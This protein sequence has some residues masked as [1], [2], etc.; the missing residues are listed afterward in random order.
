LFAHPQGVSILY[1]YAVSAAKGT[2]MAEPLVNQAASATTDFLTE[3]LGDADLVWRY[4]PLLAGGLARMGLQDVEGFPDYVVDIGRVLGRSL[5]ETVVN[6]LGLVLL[7]VGLVF[8]GPAGVVVVGALDLALSGAGVVQAYLRE[9]EQELAAGASDFLAADQRLAAPPDYSDTA[10]A[11]AAAFVSAFALLG[12]AKQ[13]LTAKRRFPEKLSKGRDWS[14]KVPLD[15]R[16]RSQ[17]FYPR[18]KLET[19]LDKSG[20]TPSLTA[21]DMRGT[22][23]NRSERV[24]SESERLTAQKMTKRGNALSPEEAARLGPGAP[25]EL[26]LEAAPDVGGLEGTTAPFDPMDYNTIPVEDIDVA[27]TRGGA[28]RPPG[29]RLVG[30]KDFE[31][32]PVANP[33]L[34]DP[35]QFKRAKRGSGP[36]VTREEQVHGVFFRESNP[37]ELTEWARRELPD[38]SFDPLIPSV[39]V[40]PGNLA[41]ADHIVAVEL[42]K[43]FPNFPL[44]SKEDQF[45]ILHM[46]ENLMPVSKRV[47]ESRGSMPFS[48]WPGMKGAPMPQKIRQAM[49]KRETELAALIQRRINELFHAQGQAKGVAR[50]LTSDLSRGLRLP[51]AP[52]QTLQQFLREVRSEEEPAGGWQRYLE[53]LADQAQTAPVSP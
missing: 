38:G 11:S 12:P 44:L 23:V 17:G 47:N 2:E 41:E 1:A 50:T 33:K 29:D 46:R 4:V 25:R 3:L 19:Q 5:A 48:R 28:R 36:V 27:T 34:D 35:N 20:A 30:K 53:R 21:T 42:I 15:L 7:C 31:L 52:G 49:I 8:T 24:G 13:L 10:L 39:R 32:A 45:F 16:D 37:P 43:Q 14:K 51:P 26:D 40:E 9:R 22:R 6:H 18:A